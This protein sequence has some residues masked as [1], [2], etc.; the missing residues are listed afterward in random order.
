MAR[1]SHSVSAELRLFA[2]YLSNGSLS[3]LCEDILPEDFNFERVL[4]EPSLL[5]QVFAIFGNTLELDEN[6]RV[7]N[8]SYV[9]RRISQYLRSEFDRDYLV[10][11]PFESWEIELHL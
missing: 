2:F 7:L 8:S 11:P 6:G 9:Y 10:E 5:E 4:C 3:S 1:L